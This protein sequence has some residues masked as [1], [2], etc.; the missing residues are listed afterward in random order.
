MN[1]RV[2]STF[3][4]LWIVLLWTWVCK[5]LSNSSTFNSF[6]HPEVGL[7]GQMAVLFFNFLRN[8]N[9]VFCR[10]CSRL[11]LQPAV[12]QGWN[13]FTFSCILVVLGDFFFFFLIKQASYLMGV[14]WDLTVVL[15]F[16]SLTIN[17]TEDLSVWF[18]G[19]FYEIISFNLSYQELW[20]CPWICVRF[21]KNLHMQS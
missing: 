9:T 16:I 20:T 6:V 13:L 1:I 18:V 17:N 5:H 7:L 11:I 4:L 14:R 15:T 21:Q 2:A 10:G 19:Y 12:Y 8:H 3:W